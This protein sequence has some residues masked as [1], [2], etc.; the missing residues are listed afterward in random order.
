MSIKLVAFDTTSRASPCI[1]FS[2]DRNTFKYLQSK[3]SIIWNF[4]YYIWVACM[5]VI[6]FKVNLD[7]W[8]F[9]SRQHQNNQSCAH[10][11][12]LPTKFVR[13]NRDRTNWQMCLGRRH[14]TF[15]TFRRYYTS[16]WMLR[17]R[18]RNRG[19]RCRRHYSTW[20]RQRYSIHR[21]VFRCLSPGNSVS[22]CQHMG[23]KYRDYNILIY[24][25]LLTI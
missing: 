9:T 19:L 20:R 15:L 5:C 14:E 4:L 23:K 6:K 16:M 13:R 10:V 25:L 1:N 12:K 17:S 24:N 18:R 2:R 21:T 8:R 3:S 7:L 11:I 22:V